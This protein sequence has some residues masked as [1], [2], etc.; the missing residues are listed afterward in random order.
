LQVWVATWPAPGV[1]K[2]TFV[3]LAASIFN[4]PTEG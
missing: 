2:F 4:G 1:V 3:C